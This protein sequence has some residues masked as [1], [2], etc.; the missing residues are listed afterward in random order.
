V[1]PDKACPAKKGD[2]LPATPTPAGANTS[3]YDY[4][5]TVVFPE[6]G[7]GA[8]PESSKTIK[9]KCG[10]DNY[11]EGGGTRFPH[12]LGRGGNW[13][14]ECTNA[15][16]YGAPLYRQFLTGTSTSRE[17]QTWNTNCSTA[18]QRKTDAC[19]W[20]FV[21]MGGQST[22]QRSSLTANHGTYFLDTSVSRDKQWTGEAFTTTRP[23][24]D[25]NVKASDDCFPRSVNV[26][27]KGQTY[28]IF[29]LFAKPATK[30]TYQ[31]Y[32]GPGFSLATD[33]KAIRPVLDTMPMPT[34]NSVTWP[35][36]W[37]KN[38][39]D[40]TA[41]GGKGTAG[42]GVLQVTVDF[43]DQTDLDP[44][45]QCK[46]VTFCGVTSGGACGCSLKDTD[47]LALA[48]PDRTDSTDSTGKVV[49]KGIKNGA[50]EKACSQW[51]VK[52]LD[53]PTDPIIPPDPKKNGPLGFSFKMY[54]DPDDQGYLHRPQ[55]QPFPTTPEV[56]TKEPNPDWLTM[57]ATTAV[58]P[59]K[60]K[61][62]CHYSSLPTNGPGACQI[63]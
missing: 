53:F 24:D 42:C 40:D 59:D 56:L 57:F 55:P 22:Y 38:Y 9:R 37:T 23:C 28:D 6:C 18:A 8:L 32:V 10:D 39:N 12:L 15:S 1:T 36:K 2:P 34:I 54:A 33:L 30:Q 49:F 4:V 61:G 62:E 46:P 19:R 45:S 16:C 58:E 43:S 44:K 41:C 47:S 52:D 14:Q 60:S 7:I 50:C 51:A 5:T 20:P 48:D 13:S 63:P 3:P 25:P 21:R 17:L 11:T 35:T 29:F 31:I 26:F 27:L